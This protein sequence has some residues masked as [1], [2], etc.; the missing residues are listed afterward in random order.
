MSKEW[1]LR[2]ANFGFV[3]K[4]KGKQ[5]WKVEEIGGGTVWPTRGGLLQAE[6]KMSRPYRR[7]ERNWI[8]V[9]PENNV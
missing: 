7:K 6:Q 1:Y 4:V 2:N 8:I 9:S 3:F 5:F